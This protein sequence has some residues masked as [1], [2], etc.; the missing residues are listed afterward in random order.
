MRLESWS[1]F[2]SGRR[3][4]GQKMDHQLRKPARRRAPAPISKPRAVVLAPALGF[5]FAAGF[6][7]LVTKSIPYALGIVV[8]PLA[9]GFARD[10]QSC[11]AENAFSL[12]PFGLAAL[13][14]GLVSLLA[15]LPSW[16]VPRALRTATWAFSWLV[17]FGL[18][19]LSYAHALE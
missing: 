9:G 6:V 2:F 10:W 5:G 14:L 1:P 19:L 16:R 18:G 12:L 3:Y 7:F 4:A 13:G 8:G 11:C 17:W 15:P